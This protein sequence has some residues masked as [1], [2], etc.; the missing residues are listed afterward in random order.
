MFLTT[1]NYYSKIIRVKKYSSTDTTHYITLFNF[2][3]YV[4]VLLICEFVFIYNL[5]HT[6]NIHVCVYYTVVN[7]IVCLL[8]RI[9]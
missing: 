1:V 3:F 5:R 6:I 7:V 4:T 2:H 9:L 8:R